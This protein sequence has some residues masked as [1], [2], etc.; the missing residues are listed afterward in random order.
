MVSTSEFISCTRNAFR[1]LVP[2][3]KESAGR[4]DKSVQTKR[5][6]SLVTE[7]DQAVESKLVQ[8]FQQAFPEVPVL[9][10]EGAIDQNATDAEQMYSQFLNSDYQITIDPIDGTKNFIEG[11]QYYC[12]AAALSARKDGGIWPVAGVIAVPEEDL[13]YWSD[14]RGTF[15]EQVSTG[16]MLEV[17]PEVSP[18]QQISVNSRDRAWLAAHQLTALLPTISSGSS[19]HDFLGTVLGR[20]TASVVGAQRL[21]DLMAP[22]A[23]ALRAGLV[24]RDLQG[25]QHIKSLGIRDLSEE[26]VSRPWGLTRKMVLARPGTRLCELVGPLGK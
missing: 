3:V 14:E 11:S 1:E 18:K 26:I 7:I 25:G 20:R 15:S 13:L 24:L 4:P 19:V 10:E 23:L 8:I 2:F 16:A 6:G 22:L 17:W 5:D 21:W 12:I 9:G